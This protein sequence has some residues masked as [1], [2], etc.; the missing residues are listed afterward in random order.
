MP[1]D[2][3]AALKLLS[4]GCYC[5]L[6][7]LACTTVPP[8]VVRLSQVA[9]DDTRKLRDGYRSLV[10]EHFATLRQLRE[11]QFSERV[12]GPYVEKAIQEGRVVDVIN[13]KVVWNDDA[14]QFV[15]PDPARASLQKLDTLNMWYRQV[16]SDIGTLRAS[17]FSDIDALESSV[18]NKLDE[19]FGRVLTADTT[20]HAYLVS[21]QKV[22]GAQQELLREIGIEDLPEKINGALAEASEK[23]QTWT[24]KLSDADKKA[25]EAKQ[26]L[27]RI[28]GK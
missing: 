19:A 25:N 21:I 17:A 6:T 2:L 15:P 3:C 10:R 23:A 8:E 4:V 16:S 9:T 12:L 14:G 24:D 22:Q 7:L 11:Q 5:A 28:G 1:K 26:K 27:K 20:I 13:G 18:L